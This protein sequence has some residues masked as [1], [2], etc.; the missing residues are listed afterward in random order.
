M[1]A[2]A[3]ASAGELSQSEM[4]R[5]RFIRYA[6]SHMELTTILTIFVRGL[7]SGRF[8]VMVGPYKE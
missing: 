5:L 3:H 6:F 4:R 7:Q 2:A 8:I 1:A